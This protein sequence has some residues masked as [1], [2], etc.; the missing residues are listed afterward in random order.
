MKHNDRIT[1]GTVV[2]RVVDTRA[3]DITV[4]NGM[5]SDS[6]NPMSQAAVTEQVEKLQR[7]IDGTPTNTWSQNIN[8]RLTAVEGV[9]AGDG[10]WTKMW[11][12]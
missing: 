7:Q 1:D 11:I 10:I 6:V 9:V 4:H 3:T 2:W 8:E 5:G 12:N